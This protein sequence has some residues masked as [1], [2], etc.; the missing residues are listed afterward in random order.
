MAGLLRRVRTYLG[1]LY[2]G[3][4]LDKWT[5]LVGRGS[6]WANR[7][8]YPGFHVGRAPRVYGRL[9]LTM[10]GDGEIVL[11]DEVQA[12]SD[13]RRSDLSVYSRCRMT[14]YPGARIRIGDRV[15]LTG[16]ILTCR[17]VIE[18]G[19]GTRF[20]PNVTIVDSDFHVMWP[21]EQRYQLAP[22]EAEKG[23]HI[24]RNVWIGMNSVILKNVTIGDGAVIGAGSVVTRD[25]PANALA[26]GNPARVIRQLDG[27]SGG[28]RAGETGGG[29]AAAREAGG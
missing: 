23:V 22:L 18:I 29:P 8:L 15:F 10:Y 25:I 9:G 3:L 20:A 1:Q 28:G 19:D 13:W 26:A 21:P 7:L 12:I 11:G 16:T 14:T 4:R 6:V 5:A 24:G 2:V 27:P 17:K